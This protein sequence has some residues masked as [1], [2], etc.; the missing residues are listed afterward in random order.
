MK[1]ILSNLAIIFLSFLLIFQ[2]LF[3][4]ISPGILKKREKIEEFNTQD[5]IKKI[6][7]PR[8]ILA[9]FSPKNHGL[10]FK[11]SNYWK[12]DLDK[13]G[14]ILSNTGLEESEDISMEEYMA[15]KEKPSRVY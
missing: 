14:K 12:E 9:N 2:G 13:I 4:W 5:M 3:L 1:K 15:L 6:F 10:I 11:I 7:T 8:Y